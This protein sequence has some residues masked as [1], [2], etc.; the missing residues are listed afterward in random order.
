MSTVVRYSLMRSFSTT[1]LIEVTCAPWMPRSVFAAS[2]TAAS[3]A[4]AKLSGDEP[5]IVMTLAI[6]AIRAPLDLEDDPVVVVGRVAAFDDPNL[7]DLDLGSVRVLPKGLVD[8][9][10][11]LVSNAA[12]PLRVSD[13]VRLVP[14]PVVVHVY[15]P[16]R[17]D[18]ILRRSDGRGCDTPDPGDVPFALVFPS[19][20]LAV[21]QGE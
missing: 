6:P 5:M 3:A 8:G 9:V 12:V 2:W 16:R 19:R 14:G 17:V 21:T 1:A 7:L 20:P 13:P 10:S 11:E 15:L 4:L 18:L